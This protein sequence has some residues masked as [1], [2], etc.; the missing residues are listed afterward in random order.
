MM[1][2]NPN[3]ALLDRERIRGAT[4]MIAEGTDAASVTNEQIRQVAADVELFCKRHDIKGKALAKAVGY[5]P[6]TISEFLAGKYAGKS[7][8]VAI[9]LEGWLVEEEQRRA[10]P[11]TTQF[12]WTNV[13]LEIKSVANYALDRRS[14]AL[15]Y[16]PDTS[17]IGKTTALRAIHQE[18]GPRRSS[19]VTIDKVDANPTGLLKKLCKG[20]GIQDSGSNKQRFDRCVDK[21]SSADIKQILPNGEEVRRSH[22]LLIDQVHNLRWSKN[23]KPFY[24][25]T[26]LFDAT[27]T[28]QLWCGTADLVAYLER[29]QVKNADESLAQVCRRI[30]PRVDLMESIRPGGGGGE[31]LVTIEQ[32]RAMFAKNKMRLTDTAARFLCR[33]CNQ[34]DGGAVGLCVQIVEYATMLAEMRRLPSIDAGLLQEALRRGLSPRRTELLMQRL[35]IEPQKPAVAKVG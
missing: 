28:A 32:V 29:Q 12:V 27:N 24:H 34:P 7:G 3:Q 15:V 5:S 21:L 31:P 22:L 26:D 4:R 8:Q 17:G 13:A 20:L 25:L 9:D 10:R 2:P 19:L 23:D 35:E 30:F 11:A 1:N 6:T 33:L 16:G 14:I 18:M